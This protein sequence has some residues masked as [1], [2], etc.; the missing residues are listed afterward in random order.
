V[1][2]HITAVQQAGLT[3]L[4]KGEQISFELEQGRQGNCTGVPKPFW[5]ATRDGLVIR[6]LNRT[7]MRGC[8]P[9]LR[10]WRWQVPRI[11]AKIASGHRDGPLGSPV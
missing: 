5:R 10:P 7:A 2:V 3:T 11:I 4:K 1:F 9:R 8:G 6:L